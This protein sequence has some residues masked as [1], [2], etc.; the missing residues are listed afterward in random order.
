MERQG[1][2]IN[3]DVDWVCSE[4]GADAMTQGDYRQVRSNYCP[5]CG[6]KM[7]ISIHTPAC[8]DSP[9]MEHLMEMC[10][11]VKRER[12]AAVE[13]LSIIRLCIVCEHGMFQTGIPCDERPD[14]PADGSCDFKWRGAK[15]EKK[16]K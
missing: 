16:E 6:A 10:E 14:R 9:T 15:G 1:R 3:E 13:D 11:K 8:G 7:D 4:C 5:N 2:W 12:D